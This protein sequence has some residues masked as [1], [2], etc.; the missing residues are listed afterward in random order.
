MDIQLLYVTFPSHEAAKTL[1]RT[2][3]ES[4]L[5]ACVNIHQIDSLYVWEARMEE[6]AE[7]VAIFKTLESH[8]PELRACIEKGHPYEVPC[9]LSWPVRVN[10]SYADWVG[11]CLVKR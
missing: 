7:F 5:A 9:I 10:P 3:L 2:A 4:G 11:S 8:E 6:N 1:G